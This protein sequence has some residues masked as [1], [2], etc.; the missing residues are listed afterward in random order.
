MCFEQIVR[1]L[2]GALIEVQY[3]AADISYRMSPT[4]AATSAAEDEAIFIALIAARRL[5]QDVLTVSQRRSSRMNEPRRLIRRQAT[6]LDRY[7]GSAPA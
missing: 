2:E 5:L 4:P 3:A 1:H 7:N 6:P